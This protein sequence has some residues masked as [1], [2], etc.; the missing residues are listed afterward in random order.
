MLI[1]SALAA[2]DF[3]A[4]V[5]RKTK[6]SADGEPL[7]KMKVKEAYKKHM[8]YTSLLEGQG[9]GESKENLFLP[10]LCSLINI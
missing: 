4:N 10:I 5:N 8:F 9:R 7:Y 3:N 2:I 6:M 1:R